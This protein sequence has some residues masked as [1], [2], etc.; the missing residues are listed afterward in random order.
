MA[1]L[2]PFSG[3]KMGGPLE[4]MLRRGGQHDLATSSKVDILDRTETFRTKLAIAWTR[5]NLAERLRALPGD[6]ER[7]WDDGSIPAAKRR[8]ILFEHWDACEDRLGVNTQGIP[9]SAVVIVD[10]ERL[11]AAKK[12]RAAILR[13]INRRLGSQS[14][15]AFSLAEL[16]AFNARRISVEPFAPYPE[17]PS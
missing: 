8:E 4:W 1:A 16:R 15:Q 10:R 3:I 12:A 14:K 13:F 9:T 5:T 2:N 17:S 6:L 11:A 7:L